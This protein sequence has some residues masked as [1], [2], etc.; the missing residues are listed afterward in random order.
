[1]AVDYVQL[2]AACVAVA[3][4]T[5]Y[6]GEH[7]RKLGEESLRTMKQKLQWQWAAGKRFVCL[8]GMLSRSA[9][10]FLASSSWQAEHGDV[11]TATNRAF[12]TYGTTRSAAFMSCK[13]N[14]WGPH[15]AVCQLERP[16]G[17]PGC[18]ARASP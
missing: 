4:D 3:V 6:V 15:L 18:S 16:G 8:P 1:M 11:I 7:E 13:A 10:V 9:A 17:T 5:L 14:Y 12:A 2:D